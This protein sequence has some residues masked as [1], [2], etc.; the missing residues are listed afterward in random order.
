[1]GNFITKIFGEGSAKVIDSLGDVVDKFV[2]TSQEKEEF[3][4][5]AEKVIKNFEKESEKIELE[6]DKIELERDKLHFKA[7]EGS[8]LLQITALGQDDKFAKRFVY[9]LA[10]SVFLCS[11]SI[12]I[13]LVFVEIPEGNKRILDMCLGILVGSGLVS[14]L[15]YFYGSSRGSDKK[16]DIMNK[17]KGNE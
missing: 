9:Y 7:T 16:T 5:E 12:I 8:K 6:R 14:V 11:I 3:K 13:L 15:N 4:L 10:A 2:T 1:M 17:F